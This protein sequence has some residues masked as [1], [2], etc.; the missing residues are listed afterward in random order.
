MKQLLKSAL[1]A[2]AAIGM[3]AS[4]QAQADAVADFYKGKTI[5][6]FIGYGPGGGYDAYGRTVARHM[7]KHIPGN[8]N[9]IAKNRP[10]AGSLILANEVGKTLR[11]DGTAIAIIGRAQ[12]L[13]PLYGN[14]KATFD[15]RKFNWLGSANNEVSV[16]VAWHKT[17]IMSF[18][19]LKTKG[20][21]VGGTG[22]GADTDS[23]PRI[24]NNIMGTKL[25]LVTGYPGGNDV[26]LAMER[27]E[28]EGRCGYSYSSLKSRRGEWL[29]SGKVRILIQMST[30]KH[31]EMPDIPFI[32]D[33]A[34]SD[35]DR[36]VLTMNFSAQ[37]MGRP[38]V[39]PPGV[40]ADR[41]K[42]LQAAFDATMKDPA[43]L[44]DTKKQKLA[45]APVSGAEIQKLVAGMFAQPKSLIAAAR[46]AKSSA[47]KLKI[48]KIKVAWTIDKGAIKEILKGGRTV[49]YSM[50]GGKT[51][52]VKISGSRT[53][54]KI[55]G[56]KAKRKAFK[57]GMACSFKYPEG[58]KGKIEAKEVSCP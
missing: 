39:A 44:A 28:L 40:P 15:P 42:A 14:K 21:I 10:G 38:F 48:S 52:K 49:V 1:F 47:A 36:K 37:A 31:P 12:V 55:K 7:G 57:V 6:V 9:M 18:E 2:S 8:P 45:V 27:G 32:M 58:A 22:P 4:G 35:A 30:A 5:T 19:D 24:L 46:D 16:C 17:K 51:G 33:L 26:L 25:K 3:L 53:K 54:I 29:K 56:A 20:M 41:V 43:F 23:F 13:E 34:K 11:K 50:A